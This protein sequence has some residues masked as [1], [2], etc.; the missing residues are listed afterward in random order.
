MSRETWLRSGKYAAILCSAVSVA[1][2]AAG[3]HVLLAVI[4]RVRFAARI[5]CEP[6]V[7]PVE[8][9]A[10]TS[11][12]CFVVVAASALCLLAVAACIMRPKHALLSAGIMALLLLAFF[13]LLSLTLATQYVPL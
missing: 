11:A 6:L 8:M 3:T 1:S 9:L 4:R 13:A 12:P 2:V 5:R 10:S 7:R